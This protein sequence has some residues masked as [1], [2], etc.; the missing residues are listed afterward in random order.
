MNV[1]LLP[2]SNKRSQQNFINTVTNHSINSR[3]VEIRKYHPSIIQENS[4]DS[5]PIWGVT[6]GGKDR[7]KNN[8][9]K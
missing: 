9:R 7:N 4:H 8:G 3:T 1:H 2:Y 5:Y 6:D